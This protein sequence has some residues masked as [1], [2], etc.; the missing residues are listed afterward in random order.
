[1][2][3]NDLKSNC[4]EG[5]KYQQIFLFGDKNQGVNKGAEVCFFTCGMTAPLSKTLGIRLKPKIASD[6]NPTGADEINYVT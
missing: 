5:K 1:M 4:N 6:I 3:F 2:E